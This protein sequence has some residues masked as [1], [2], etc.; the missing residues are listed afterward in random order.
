MLKFYS[1][2]KTLLLVTSKSSGVQRAVMSFYIIINYINGLDSYGLTVVAVDDY[3]VVPVLEGKV[4]HV[5]AAY[6]IP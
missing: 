2:I 1:Y 5:A 3:T 4:S 6:P